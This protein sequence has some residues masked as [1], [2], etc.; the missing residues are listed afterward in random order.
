MKD[1]VNHIS[2]T[3]EII[4]NNQE[5]QGNAFCNEIEFSKRERTLQIQRKNTRNELKESLINDQIIEEARQSFLNETFEK[6]NEIV[7]SLSA[8]RLREAFQ[9]MRR[10]KQKRNR[11]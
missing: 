9:R 6:C 10:L 2:K 4:F 7:A 5:T 8:N 1:N 11:R 3:L